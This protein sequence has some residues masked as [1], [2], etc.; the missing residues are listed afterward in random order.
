MLT[1]HKIKK[2]LI[3]YFS[4]VWML[5]RSEKKNFSYPLYF[6]MGA[7]L[8]YLVHS[9]NLNVRFFLMLTQIQFSTKK[10]FLIHAEA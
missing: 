9:P 4:L 7:D 5:N 3:L 6:E 10:T 2:I 1:K 8:V